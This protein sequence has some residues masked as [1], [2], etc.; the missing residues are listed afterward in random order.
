M[1]LEDVGQSAQAWEA[2]WWGDCV[3]TFGEEAKQLTY[4]HLMGLVNEPRLGK[5]PVYDLAGKSVVDLGGGPVSM[6]L[7]TVNGGDLVVVDPCPYPNWV[8]AR[9]EAARIE[10][11]EEEAEAW[12]VGAYEGGLPFDEAWIYNVLQ[13]VVDPEKVI[14][15]ARTHAPVLRIFEWIETE[16]NVGHPHSLHADDLNDWCGGVGTVRTINENGA[17]GICYS[18]VFNL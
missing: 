16:T 9:Y 17:V 15:T 8:R 1:T 18:G 5:W 3:Q 6:L 14:E 13:H 4:A 11:I 2:E 12:F 10:Q 7:K